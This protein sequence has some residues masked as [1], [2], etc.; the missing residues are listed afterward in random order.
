MFTVFTIRT[1]ICLKCY[2]YMK[3]F[4]LPIL[5]LGVEKDEVR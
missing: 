4:L 3:I 5:M 1:K 2:L